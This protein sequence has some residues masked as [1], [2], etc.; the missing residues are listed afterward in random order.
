MTPIEFPGHNVVYAKDQPEYQPLPALHM[1]DAEGTVISCWQLTEEEK[2]IIAKEGK[3]YI[4]MLT[5]NQA[6]TPILPMVQLGDD[7]VI[8]PES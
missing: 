6:L 4:K 8:T 3:L 5:F 7:I 2:E 1:R